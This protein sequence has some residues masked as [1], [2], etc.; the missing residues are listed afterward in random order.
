MRRPWWPV[1]AAL[2]ALGTGTGAGSYLWWL[3][4]K[5]DPAARPVAR[6]AISSAPA[7]SASADSKQEAWAKL[8]GWQRTTLLP[9]EAAWQGLDAP[10][11]QRWLAVA[12]RMRGLSPEARGRVQIRMVEWARLSPTMRAQARLQYVYAKRVPASQ[13]NELWKKYQLSPVESARLAKAQ[14]DA[15]M[16]APAL[17]QVKP[18][19]TTVPIT[20]LLR[21]A[22]A[23]VEGGLPAHGQDGDGG[24]EAG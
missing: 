2:V 3:E 13:R 7:A 1:I 19:A 15:S 4:S 16:V 18:G 9:L 10:N 22:T 12:A 11:R 6:S 5:P 21:P 14:S 24:P 20:Q 23:E 17:A 8:N